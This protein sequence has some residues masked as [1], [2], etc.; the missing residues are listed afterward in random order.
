MI[1]SSTKLFA[2]DR[3]GYPG[4]EREA[5]PGSSRHHLI[6]N[7]WTDGSATVPV[8]FRIYCPDKDSKN[9]NDYFRDMLRAADERKLLQGY[10]IFDSWYSSIDNLKL[11]RSLK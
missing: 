3:T 9:K 7:I 6:S 5:S 8:D 10:V 11:I 2:A 4:L 1:V